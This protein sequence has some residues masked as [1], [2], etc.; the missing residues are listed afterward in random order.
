M[1]NLVF[2]WDYDGPIGRINCSL[3]Y[4]FHYKQIIDEIENVNKIAIC[5]EISQ[6]P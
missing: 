6:P 2:I 4:N 5:L 3:P 1:T